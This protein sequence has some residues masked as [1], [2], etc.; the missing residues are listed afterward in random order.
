MINCIFHARCADEG[1]LTSLCWCLNSGPRGEET[2]GEQTSRSDE[3]VSSKAFVIKPKPPSRK[4]AQPPKPV[5]IERTSSYII[6]SKK[7][8]QEGGV[9]LVRHRVL[10]I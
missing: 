4:A 1:N 3:M 10:L 7:T 6:Q 8:V 2:V 5:T 9:S